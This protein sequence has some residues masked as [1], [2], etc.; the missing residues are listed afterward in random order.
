MFL[1]VKNGIC[2]MYSYKNKEKIKYF[3]LN[4]WVVIKIIIHL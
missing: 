2:P 4:K 1:K 3:I